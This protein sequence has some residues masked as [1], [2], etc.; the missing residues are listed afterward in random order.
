MQDKAM[1]RQDPDPTRSLALPPQQTHEHC[2]VS[3]IIKALN[4]E[5]GIAATLESALR[6]VAAVGGEVVLADACSSDQTVE[7]ARRYPVRIVQL[8]HPQ[9][10]CCGAGPQLGFQHA[11]GEFLYLVDGDMLLAEDFLPRALSFMRGHP[12]VA[13]VGGRVIEKNLSS[14][15]YQMRH[16]LWAEG[17]CGQVS[18]LDG[19]GLYRRSA[20]EQA[21]YFSDRN[22]HSYEEFELATRL[23]SLGWVLWRMPLEAVSHYG[24]ETPP[25]QL[26]R[27]RWRNG[28]LFGL[29]ELLRASGDRQRLRLLLREL[30]EVRLYAVV[31]LGW[32]AL[33]AVLLLWPAALAWRLTLLA[34]ALAAAVGLM[35]WRKRSFKRGVYAIVSWNFNA[36]GMLFG[37][38]RR[39]TD[40][41]RAI[42]SRLL[43]DTLGTPAPWVAPASLTSRI[44]PGPLA[45][46]APQAVSP[47][48]YTQPLSPLEIPHAN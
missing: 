5:K 32:A 27:R 38:L 36:A 44:K 20:I 33:L 40:A 1:T 3:I 10:R 42:E 21:G 46:P 43:Q 45:R 18:R 48:R 19:G 26:L 2:P 7:I 24:H 30:R 6:A 12:D 4:E 11:H 13:G 25:Y 39:R 16:E 35:S 17:Q 34:A 23:R 22:L 47:E 41:S 28:Y 15:E 8:A 29:G 9:E 31:V 14:P 37:L